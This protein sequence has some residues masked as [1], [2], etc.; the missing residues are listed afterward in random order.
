MRRDDLGRFM[1]SSCSRAHRARVHDGRRS[2]GKEGDRSR[3]GRRG[4][5][6]PGRAHRCA[7]VHWRTGSVAD[8]RPVELRS[9]VDNPYYPLKPGTTLVYRGVRDGQTQVDRVRVTKRTKKILGVACV[10]VRDV[11]RHDGQLLEQTWDW[12]AQDVDGN[13]WYFGEDTT[14]YD[15]QGHVESTEG[16]WEAGVR[17]AAAGIIM[18]ASPQPPDGYQQEFLA[19]HA[20]DQAW[21]LSRGGSLRIPYGV[22]HH[23]LLTMEWTPLEPDVIDQKSYAPG[24][25]IVREKAVAGG[26]ELAELVAVHTR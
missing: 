2:D 12:F 25:G 19:G 23:V 3:L 11:A 10:V 5:V 20:E 24:L 21:V 1:L 13:V 8:D 14:A 16:S 26:D 7:S 9:K 6:R 18:E 22:V 17:G 4:A 15:S